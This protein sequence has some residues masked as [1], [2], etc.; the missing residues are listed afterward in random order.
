[1][2]NAAGN[3]HGTIAG[4]SIESDAIAELCVNACGTLGIAF[5]GLHL[6]TGMP[7]SQNTTND[8]EQD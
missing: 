6:L 8:S 5:I 3:R 4:V 7:N 1:M 2:S